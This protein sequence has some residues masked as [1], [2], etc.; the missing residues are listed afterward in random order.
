MHLSDS[1]ANEEKHIV[2]KAT[3]SIRSPII[4]LCDVNRHVNVPQLLSAVGYEFLRTMAV[5]LNDG[6][7]DLLMKQCGFQLINPNERWFPGINKNK[8]LF[9]SW[10]WC[11]GRTPEFSVVKDIKLKSNHIVKL[12]IIVKKGIVDAI[13]LALKETE[14]MSVV[15]N[16]IGKPFT[17]DSL[18]NVELSLKDASADNVQQA[19]GF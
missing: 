15:S 18:Q 17:E 19:T 14:E 16:M 9:Q 3:K 13:S 11:F 10:D 4:N 12:K 8:E 2:S 5:E 1:L 6:G 7:R